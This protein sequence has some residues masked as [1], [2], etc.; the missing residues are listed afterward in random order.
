MAER[1]TAFI[2]SEMSLSK[3]REAF[4]KPEQTHTDDGK[5]YYWYICAN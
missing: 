5:I 3:P 2:M 1:K 4:L